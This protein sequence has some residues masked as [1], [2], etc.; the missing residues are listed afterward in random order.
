MPCCLTPNVRRLEAEAI[1]DAMLRAAG[2]IDLQVQGAPVNDKSNRRSAFLRVKRNALNPMLRA[3]DF[4]EPHSAVGRRDVTNVP[5]QSLLMMNSP[6]VAEYAS[7]LA[8]QL[9]DDADA[10]DF[11]DRVTNLYERVLTR[12]P[13]DTET[14]AMRDHLLQTKQALR[15]RQRERDR[16]Q[17]KLDTVQAKLD[18]IIEPKRA[19][20]SQQAGR[21]ADRCGCAA[22]GALGIHRR[23][24]G[25]HRGSGRRIAGRGPDRQWTV[26][27][28]PRWLR[29]DA[30]AAKTD[31]GKDARG[32]GPARQPGP[33]RRRRDH[34]ANQGRAYF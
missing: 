7:Q 10:G 31:P 6:L 25:Q 13:T 12:W 24:T 28:Q 34:L 1:R 3:F 30:T 18:A 27:R 29:H 22:A 26:G 20:L 4:P 21:R 16:W 19:E 33:A 23:S 11:Q 8:G 2:T 5:A 14:N 17:A 15:R 9:G 32:L